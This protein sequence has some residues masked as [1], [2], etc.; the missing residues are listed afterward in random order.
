[1]PLRRSLTLA[2]FLVLGLSPLV[3]A[4]RAQDSIPLPE[5]PRPDLMRAEWVNLNGRWR[6]RFDGADAGERE[7][8][9][10]VPL[11]GE[12]RILVPFPWGS[13]LSGVPDSAEIAWYERTIR[14]P[15]S[16]RGRRV[17]L[18]VGASDWKTSIHLD[19]ERLGEHEGGYTP[20]SV[21]P[22]RGPSSSRASR[23]TGTRVA[24]GRRSTSRREEPCR[25]RR[26]T[27][28][29]CSRSVAIARACA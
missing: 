8:W 18:V 9:A 11:A 5:H 1:M 14:V 26:R 20:F 4:M 24:S 17:Y 12:R 27:S 21:E 28:R 15:E 6:F 2:P 25:W 10:R 23:A 22:W 7:G 29:P 3:T 13:P 19:G 16:W